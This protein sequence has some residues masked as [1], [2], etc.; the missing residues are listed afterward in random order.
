MPVNQIIS[1][2]L[3]GIEPNPETHALHIATLDALLRAKTPNDFRKALIDNHAIFANPDAFADAREDDNNFLSEDAIEDGD[4][5]INALRYQAAEKRILLGLPTGLDSLYEIISKEEGQFREW[6]A[7]QPDSFGAHNWAEQPYI[8][9]AGAIERI[10]AQAKIQAAEQLTAKAEEIGQAMNSPALRGLLAPLVLTD[11]SRVY[12]EISHLYEQKNA[13]QETLEKF[14]EF[15]DDLEV[16]DLDTEFENLTID[17]KAASIDAINTEHTIIITEQEQI[18]F[19]AATADALKLSLDPLITRDENLNYALSI[20]ERPSDDEDV[21][22]G[23]QEAEEAEEP[24]NVQAEEEPEVDEELIQAYKQQDDI[25]RALTHLKLQYHTKLI[26]EKAAL[27]EQTLTQ[28]SQTDVPEP[29]VSTSNNREGRVLT[30]RERILGLQG[31]AEAA[32]AILAT[33]ADDNV[34]IIQAFTDELYADRDEEKNR[35]LVLNEAAQAA[36]QTAERN[37]EFIRLLITVPER[38]NDFGNIVIE[39]GGVLDQDYFT[40]ELVRTGAELPALAA[41]PGA[42]VEGLQA[43]LL[44]PRQVSPTPKFERVKLEPG[45]LIYARAEFT[46]PAVNGVV[47]PEKIKVN[48]TQDHTGKVTYKASGGELNPEQSILAALKQA[49]ML[50]NNFD[51]SKG[52]AIYIKGEARYAEQAKILFA[53]LLRIKETCPAFKD[54]TIISHVTGCEGPKPESSMFGLFAQSQEAANKKFIEAH[55]PARYFPEQKMKTLTEQLTKFSDR[56]NANVQRLQEMKQQLRE[57]KLA[58][59]GTRQELTPAERIALVGRMQT[60]G[61]KENEVMDLEENSSAIMG[62]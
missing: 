50:L 23:E 56:K 7:T 20:V 27:I 4:N 45:D 6:L 18:N 54:I 5:S 10:K 19:D 58:D 55:L 15:I 57:G 52:D 62:L 17:A 53:L 29:T 47:P 49:E 51:P 38:P 34:R 33:A 2:A 16:L 40:T 35:L 25:K 8:L 42:N 21:G 13:V 60:L 22:E 39:K 31:N 14:Q 61:L 12:N 9:S 37:L 30:E 43:Q 11:A 44:N 32:F 3:E 59:D 24:N 36:R 26:R 28:I 1:E 46:K 48:I 41:I